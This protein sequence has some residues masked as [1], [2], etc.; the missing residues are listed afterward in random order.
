MG[1]T[2]RGSVVDGGG[3][4]CI[5]T[6]GGCTDRPAMRQCGTLGGKRLDAQARKAWRVIVFE[7]RGENGAA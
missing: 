7:I 6:G 4:V 1:E 2:I 3:S 5:K